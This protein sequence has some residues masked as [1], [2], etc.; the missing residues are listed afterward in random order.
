M[1]ERVDR[2]RRRFESMLADVRAAIDASAPDRSSPGPRATSLLASAKAL[3]RAGGFLEAV[4]IAFP[5][6]GLELIG[7]FE[8]VAREVHFVPDVP[9][10]R[11]V[12]RATMDRRAGAERR[13]SED[14]GDYQLW[15][16]P[17]RRIGPRRALVE[18]RFGARAGA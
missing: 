3:N 14:Q 2:L 16:Q 6:L 13:L 1:D 18:R 17:E 15:R 12:T 9:A 4:A 11:W 5:Q 7:R 10:E 8:E